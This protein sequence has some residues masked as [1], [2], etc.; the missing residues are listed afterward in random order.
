MFQLTRNTTISE[1]IHEHDEGTKECYVVSLKK[2][3]KCIKLRVLIEVTKLLKEYIAIAYIDFPKA[4]S[5][6]RAFKESAL[7]PLA[8]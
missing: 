5:S 7:G 4:L 2:V 3:T 1:R 8:P 6:S